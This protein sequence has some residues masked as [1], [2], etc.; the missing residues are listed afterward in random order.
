MEEARTADA[1]LSEARSAPDVPL[2]VVVV[3]A[4]DASRSLEGT[5]TWFGRFLMRTVS[6]LFLPTMVL[7]YLAAQLWDV[8]MSARWLVILA[9]LPALLPIIWMSATTSRM[10]RRRELTETLEQDIRS[11]LAARVKGMATE[12][13]ASLQ[14]RY[15][16]YLQSLAREG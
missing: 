6:A 12:S 3:K 2:R 14:S 13:W 5:P 15:A 1:D 4:L 10:Q 9:L 11:K 7:G 8:G 16:D